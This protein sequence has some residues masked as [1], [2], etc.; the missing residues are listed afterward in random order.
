MSF[1]VAHSGIRDVSFL[2]FSCSYSCSVDD[3]ARTRILAFEYDYAHHFIKH[4]H[5]I[6]NADWLFSG[7]ANKPN[8][9][10][11]CEDSDCLRLMQLKALG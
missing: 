8:G 6:S 10:E 5:E 7:V 1:E 4:E 2:G 11:R 3:G 9:Y